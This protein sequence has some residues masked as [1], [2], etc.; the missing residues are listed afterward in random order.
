[1]KHSPAPWKIKYKQNCDWSIYAADGYSVLGIPD[2]DQHGRPIEDAANALLVTAAPEML[3]A[4]ESYIFN[5]DQLKASKDPDDKRRIIDQQI[6]LN[7]VIRKLINKA[8]GE[9]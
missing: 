1:M 7:I 9:L 2:D 6:S 4:L 5:L 8:K 3:A